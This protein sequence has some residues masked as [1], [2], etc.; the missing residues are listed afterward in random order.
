M[1]NPAISSNRASSLTF[2]NSQQKPSRILP[3]TEL[4]T[5]EVKS[6]KPSIMKKAARYATGLLIGAQALFSSCE[7]DPSITPEPPTPPTP[8]TKTEQ[9]SVRRIM[10]S[11]DLIDTNTVKNDVQNLEFKDNYTNYN[12]KLTFSHD[13]V[14]NEHWDSDGYKMAN[15]RIVLKPTNDK[16]LFDAEFANMKNGKYVI[17][18]NGQYQ[19]KTIDGKT[20]LV[21]LF[22]HETVNQLTK[23]T[24]VQ[25]KKK[26][27]GQA[28]GEWL[29]DITKIA[30]KK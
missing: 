8:I 16:N 10:G 29:I 3:R 1:L 30:L 11:L 27:L 17:S 21:E 6:A 14:I 7:K 12:H 25:L 15:Q 26:L 19:L 13:T 5:S 22:N 23:E 2:G 18:G 28:T 4:L 20:A 9:P 24:P